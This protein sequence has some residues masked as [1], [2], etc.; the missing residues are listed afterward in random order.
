[1]LKLEPFTLGR[2]YKTQLPRKHL[3]KRGEQLLTEILGTYS[4]ASGIKHKMKMSQNT[5]V[6]QVK[7]W[8]FLVKESEEVDTGNG[9]VGHWISIVKAR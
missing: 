1:M 7:N 3:S 4:K 9:P 5:C 2:Q 6:M 8:L